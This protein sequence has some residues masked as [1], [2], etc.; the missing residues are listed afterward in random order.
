MALQRASSS[1][2]TTTR[3]LYRTARTFRTRR[4]ETL[5]TA[6]GSYM[7]RGTALDTLP[8][9]GVEV[10]CPADDCG[11]GT[12]GYDLEEATA[13]DGTEVWKVWYVC[14]NGHEF[15]LCWPRRGHEQED[16]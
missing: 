10:V 13:D 14:D 7:S 1:M 11:S 5:L 12:R 2:R 8:V 9:T 4:S 3:W 16:S 6:T 15:V